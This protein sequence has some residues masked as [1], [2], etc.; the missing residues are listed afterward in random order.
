VLASPPT[1][2]EGAAEAK[3]YSSEV[4]TPSGVYRQHLATTRVAATTY[5]ERGWVD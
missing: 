2:P 1:G 3:V 4:S 5:L